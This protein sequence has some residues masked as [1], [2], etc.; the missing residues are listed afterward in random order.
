MRIHL[1]FYISLL[2]PAH[3]DNLVTSEVIEIDSK[4]E[5]IYKVEKVLGL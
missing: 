4:G 3:P 5:E 2:E 1:V